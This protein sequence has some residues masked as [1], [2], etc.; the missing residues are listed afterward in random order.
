MI[1]N[2]T[3]IEGEI[4]LSKVLRS[5][6]GAMTVL[7]LTA[8]GGGNETN[9]S[10]ALKD[11]VHPCKRPGSGQISGAPSGACQLNDRDFR[12][13]SVC[14]GQPN[15]IVRNGPSTKAQ[16]SSKVRACTYGKKAYVEGLVWSDGTYWAKLPGWGDWDGYGYADFRWLQAGTDTP[17]GHGTR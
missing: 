5:S 13:W 10:S 3:L 11:V 1:C 17:D 12:G 8:C 4:M 6:I 9:T 15:L 16:V 14:A 7:T 2:S